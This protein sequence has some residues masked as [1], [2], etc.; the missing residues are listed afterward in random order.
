MALEARGLAPLLQVYD[1]PTSIRFYRD[2]LG[3]EVVTTSPSLGGTDRFHWV[4]LRLCGTELML[5][6]AHEFDHQRPP[7]P[8]PARTAAHG[9][10]G[11]YFACPDVDA[12]YQQLRAKGLDPKP[13]AIAPYGMKQLYLRPLPPISQATLSPN[14]FD[15][16]R[17]SSARCRAQP[18]APIAAADFRG[19]SWSAMQALRFSLKCSLIWVVCV[20]D[21]GPPSPP[22]LALCSLQLRL[23]NQH[24]PP[25][26]PRRQPPQ[27]VPKRPRR[28]SL[29]IFL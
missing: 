1:M 4:L 16:T 10:T 7:L 26:H 5:N 24:R 25:R 9:D 15:N 22:L 3:F 29:R 14:L 17:N 23:V 13:P 2:T 11:L 12:A 21:F 6:T 8:D 18:R 20:E 27:R 28:H 19:Q